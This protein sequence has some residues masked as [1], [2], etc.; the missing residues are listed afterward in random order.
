MLTTPLNGEVGAFG[1][2]RAAGVSGSRPEE[3]N[4]TMVPPVEAIDV[5]RLAL[6]TA[7]GH[8]SHASTL[9]NDVCGDG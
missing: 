2:T 9:R 6:A 3:T 8:R 7:A 1:S 5:A 4:G